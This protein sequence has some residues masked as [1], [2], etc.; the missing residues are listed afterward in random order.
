MKNSFFRIFYLDTSNWAS[1]YFQLSLCLSHWKRFN[2]SK[3]SFNTITSELILNI[4]TFIL[5]IHFD[6]C[7]LLPINRRFHSASHLWEVSAFTNQSV[8]LKFQLFKTL[9]KFNSNTI[10][11]EPL[12]HLHLIGVCY[13]QQ[14]LRV[15][16]STIHNFSNVPLLKQAL[17]NFPF[18]Q[19]LN[20]D[21]CPL[22]PTFQNSCN[23]DWCLL[24]PTN[25]WSWSF[26]YS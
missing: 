12:C 20:F 5:L 19:P 1:K 18:H 14:I 17:N 21:W 8:K 13:H 22:L 23:F 3:F 15:E 9:A 2:F 10:S 7:L 4:S 6:C 26:N 16:D 11:T 25:L 24:S